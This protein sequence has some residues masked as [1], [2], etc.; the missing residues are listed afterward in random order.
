MELSKIMEIGRRTTLHGL[1]GATEPELLSEFCAACLEAGMPLHRAMSIMDTLHPVYEGRAFHWDAER[2]IKAE[3]EYGPSDEDERASDSWR[4]SAFY[5]L[6]SNQ[7][8]SVRRR[9]GFGEPADFTS[10]D[11]M[12]EAGHTDFFAFCHSFSDLGSIGEMNAFYCHFLSR[13]PAGFSDEHISA[14]ND[15]IPS[16]GLA[17]KC[18]SLNRISRT[19]AEVYLGSDAA[20]RVLKGEIRRG[21]A[22]QISA[23][24]W[25]SD[26]V[27]YTRISDNSEPSD[28]LPMLNEYV[29]V[30]ISSIHGNGGSVLK[31]MGDGVLAIF[32]PDGKRKASGM[33]LR[34]HKSLRQELTRVNEKR[35]SEN[36]LTTD[37]YVGLHVGDVFFGNIGSDQR[38]DF[39]I[40]GPAVNEVS[41]VASMCRS[42]DLGV[43]M[44]SD[45]VDC[46]DEPD[47][48]RTA[49][50]GR[51][52]LRGVKQTKALYTLDDRGGAS[53]DG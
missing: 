23:V 14:L 51:F 19:I 47:R 2:E 27:N 20:S 3:F 30:V 40:I 38:L 24:L 49:C 16:L 34:A 17:M 46:L 11:R 31:L 22:E 33:A 26:L 43:L 42:V 28:I 45:F 1:S 21:H 53:G 48:Q 41:R 8:S 39:T 10:L 15:L 6:R 25:F 13:D 18:T 50:V 52:A 37:V 12:H 36:K 5:F 4:R 29:E 35:H 7:A 32:R 44:S 9:I